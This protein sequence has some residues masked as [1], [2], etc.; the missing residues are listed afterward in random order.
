MTTSL[1]TLD[2]LH[3]ASTAVVQAKLIT[4]DVAMHQSA[5]VLGIES[6]LVAESAGS[7]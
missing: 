6:T 7:A 2:A 5:V 3:L 4:T 1:R